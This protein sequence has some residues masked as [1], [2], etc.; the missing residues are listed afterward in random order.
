MAEHEG[1]T[2]VND[3]GPAF[4][5][6]WCAK[7]AHIRQG[8]IWLCAAHYR[9]S[10]MRTR[11][12]RDGKTTPT[13]QE[14][15]ALIPA[16]FKCGA[17]NRQMKW[18]RHGGASSQATLQHDRSGTVRIICLACNTRHAQHPGD[19]YYEL[20]DNHKRCAS[21]DSI[22]PHSSFDKDR[23][24]PL[25]LKSSCQKCSHAAHTE[26]RIKNREYYNRKQR[27]NRARRSSA[28]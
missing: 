21:C 26:W 16:P 19:S 12:K 3:G 6:S 7:P 20:P 14:I 25:G 23:S 17:C 18:L 28:D 11:A 4:L 10:S 1:T 27:E 24:R 15:E 22:L 8:R 2:R 13:R 9:I 5:C